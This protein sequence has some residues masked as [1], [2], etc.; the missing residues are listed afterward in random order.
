MAASAELAAAT[1]AAMTSQTGDSRD[2]GPPVCRG[3]AAA[4]QAAGR[5][6]VKTAPPPGG[7]AAVRVPSCAAASWAATASPMPLAIRANAGYRLAVTRCH[8][9]VSPAAARYLR[10]SRPSGPSGP[11]YTM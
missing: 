3:R 7:L 10:R 11:M 4:C 1:A 2:C 5:V 9:P 8:Q 6:R